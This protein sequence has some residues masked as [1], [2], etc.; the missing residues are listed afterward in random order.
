MSC[1]LTV[2]LVAFAVMPACS[3]SPAPAPQS[4]QSI[5]GLERIAWDQPASGQSELSTIRYAIYVDN[6]R[7]EIAGASCGASASDSGYPCDGQLPPMTHGSHTIQLASFVVSQDGK[8]LE[9]ERTT[10]LQVFVTGGSASAAATSLRTSAAPLPV[11]A[12]VVTTSDGVQLRVQAVVD[13]LR[14]PTDLAFAQ[15]GTLVVSE[16][17]GRIRLIRDGVMVDASQPALDAL[18]TA[19][20]GGLLA[21]ALDPAFDRTH[22]LFAIYTARLSSGSVAFRLVRMRQSGDTFADEVILLDEVP[23]SPARPAASLRFGPDGKLYAAFDAGG[24]PALAGDMASFNGKV[25]RLNT[26]GSTPADQAAATPVYASGCRS[27]RGLD[28]H[29]RD[30]ALWVADGDRQGGDQLRSIVATGGPGRTTIRTRYSLPAAA[31]A[32]SMTFY[33]G[34]A[35]PAFRDNLLIASAS[36]PSLLRLRFDE[37]DPSQLVATDTLLT[38]EAGGLRAVAVGP[39]GAICFATSS[40]V[41][42]LVAGT[43][44][45]SR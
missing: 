2:A 13:G 9:S 26:D 21:L 40:A 5:T 7:S 6:N 36:G 35:V 3:P 19:T 42:R 45:A 33:R 15:D 25:L 22:L 18:T 39:D 28:W 30:G 38:S 16:L 23:A 12:N 34:T 20:G 14:E 11:P 43:G 32:T 10:P 29:P 44:T 8:V 41:E 1:R 37:R 31:S 4:G 27:P 17:A 24:D